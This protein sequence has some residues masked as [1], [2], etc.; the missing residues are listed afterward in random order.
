MIDTK[1]CTNWVREA[2]GYLGFVQLNIVLPVAGT[3]N[4]MFV[5]GDET[6]HGL[7]ECCCLVWI[8]HYWLAIYKIMLMIRGGDGK[9]ITGTP[10]KVYKCCL[11]LH[12]HSKWARFSKRRLCCS[13]YSGVV[14]GFDSKTIHSRR[15]VHSSEL[16]L[17][18]LQVP[19]IRG[20][21]YWSSGTIFMIALAIMVDATRK[22]ILRS[23]VLFFLRTPD[24]P[25]VR[26]IHDA[27]MVP[28]KLQAHRIWLTMKVYS[29]FILAGVG[30]CTWTMANWLGHQTIPLVCLVYASSLV[31]KYREE[32][33]EHGL[34]YLKKVIVTVA[35]NSVSVTT[36]STQTTL[37][38]EATLLD[39]TTNYWAATRLCMDWQWKKGFC[40]NG[41]KDDNLIEAV[42]S[43]NVDTESEAT[44]MSR[45]AKKTDTTRRKVGDGDADDSG[46]LGSFVSSHQTLLQALQLN[47]AP[48]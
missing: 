44:G 24:D 15:Q 43:H 23:G 30:T 35:H 20:F 21:L 26:L 18:T 8:R 3:I 36:S 12:A 32:M 2:V 5:G 27:L 14:V 11:K 47:R 25:N 42:E 28:L 22:K 4:R 6:T 7:I 10:R 40:P 41:N 31:T 13:Q 19:Y 34:E 29:V 1:A 46:A 9:P 38:K 17:R 16:P 45:M 33:K 48:K 39:G 37:P